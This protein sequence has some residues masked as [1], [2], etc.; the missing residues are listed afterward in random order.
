MNRA[1]TIQEVLAE[2][3]EQRD[4]ERLAAF[5]FKLLLA[6]VLIISTY[7]YIIK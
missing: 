4:R 7:I 1:R 6:H 3:R 2:Q 5:L